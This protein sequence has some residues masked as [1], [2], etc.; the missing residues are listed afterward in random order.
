MLCAVCVSI[1]RSVFLFRRLRLFLF[2]FPFSI[3]R[4]R[5]PLI[6]SLAMR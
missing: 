4:S 1:L 6:V 5:F 3:R 2:R